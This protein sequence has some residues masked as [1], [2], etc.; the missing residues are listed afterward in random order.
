[1]LRRYHWSS[2]SAL[3]ASLLNLSLIF[4]YGRHVIANDLADQAIEAMKR[5]IDL[6]GLA[7]QPDAPEHAQGKVRVNHGDARYAY[8]NSGALIC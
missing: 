3:F 4:R 7:P 8:G 6:N 2:A 5:N 1:M